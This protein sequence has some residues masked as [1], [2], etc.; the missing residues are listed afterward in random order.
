MS[1]LPVFTASAWNLGLSDNRRLFSL[2][3]PISLSERRL[4]QEGGLC[5]TDF[6]SSAR[7]KEEKQKPTCDKL[8]RPASPLKLTPNSLEQVQAASPTQ[9]PD[10]TTLFVVTLFLPLGDSH[11]PT[12]YHFGDALCLTSHEISC[13][14]ASVFASDAVTSRRCGAITGISESKGRK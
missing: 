3:N 7:T 9:Q 5:C 11:S 8:A 2:T 10:V 1:I 4:P 14:R 12:F 13:G 6:S